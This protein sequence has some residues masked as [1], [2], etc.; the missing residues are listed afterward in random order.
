M[1]IQVGKTRELQFEDKDGDGKVHLAYRN[2]HHSPPTLKLP[3]LQLPTAVVEEV[4]GYL[5]VYLNGEPPKTSQS[6]ESPCRSNMSLYLSVLS[7]LAIVIY[8]FYLAL[9]EDESTEQS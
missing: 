1:V 7:L 6:D 2:D 8:I 3:T 4:D 5:C 9:S